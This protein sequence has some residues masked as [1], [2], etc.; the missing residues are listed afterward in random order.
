MTDNIRIIAIVLGSLLV[1]SSF[2][3]FQWLVSKI[4]FRKSAIVS[5][6]NKEKDFLDIV[7]LWYQLKHKCDQFK[8]TVASD[9]L[10]EVFPLLNGVLEDEKTA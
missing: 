5:T 4:L 3:D 10:D 6:I 1:I 2:V 9:K 8:L 7:S